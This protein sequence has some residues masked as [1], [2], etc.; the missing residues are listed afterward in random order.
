MQLKN[1][2]VSA[3]ALFAM[4]GGARAQADTV[5]YWRFEN[6]SAGAPVATV[7]DITGHGNTLAP[8]TTGNPT[9]P[10]YTQ[11]NPG[12]PLHPSSTNALALDYA[13]VNF[14]DINTAAATGDINSHTFNQFTVEASVK[15]SG[16]GGYQTF[17]CKEGHGIPNSD[18]ADLASLY[19]QSPGPGDVGGQNI[20][21]IR[22]SQA[23]GH[24]IVCNG[25]TQ[26]V[27]NVW[28]NVAAVSDGTSLRLYVQAPGGVYNLDRAVPFK[29]QMFNQNRNW[30]VGRGY[31]ANNAGDRFGGQL[32]EVRVSDTALTPDA[33]L[34]APNGAP[35]TAATLAGTAYDSGASLSWTTVAGA[36]SYTLQRGTKPGGPYSTLATGLLNQTYIDSGLSDGTT[37]YYV[38]TASNAAGTGPKSNELAL[39]PLA[40]ITGTGHF[41]INF[42]SNNGGPNTTPMGPAEVAGVDPVANWNNSAVLSPGN[43]GHSNTTGAPVPLVD[44]AGNAISATVDWQGSGNGWASGIADTP[45]DFR[46]M[47]GY[48]DTGDTS[49]HTITVNGLSPAKS[50]LV[51]VY[52][53]PAENNRTGSHTIGS[54]T[55]YISSAS[56]PFT[57]TYVRSTSTDPLKPGI[58]NYC[59][60]TVSGQNSFTLTSTPDTAINGTRAVV[61]GIQVLALAVPAPPANLAAVGLDKSVG[62]T[63]N[64]V[65][66]AVSY[67]VLRSTTKGG[68]YT[69]IATGVI[70]TGYTDTGLTNGTTYYY[71][72]QS[73]NT[74]GTSPNSNEAFATPIAAAV[75]AGD[76]LLGTYYTGAALDFSA[77]NGTPFLTHIDPTINF[78]VDDPGLP[79]SPTAFPAG[80]PHDLFTTVWTGKFQAPYTGSYVIGAVTDDGVRLTVNGQTATDAIL[81]G[82]TLTALPAQ[83]LTAG[84]KYDV[85]I[86]YFQNGGGSAAQFVYSYN[87]LPNAL[88]PQ[89]QLFSNLTGVPL[90]PANLTAVAGLKSVVLNW[91]G[92]ALATG[93]SVKRST[94]AGGPYTTIAT[95]LTV[96][97]YKDTAVTGG[98]TYYYVVSATNGSGESANSNE[99]F[100]TPIAAYKPVAYWRFE[101]GTA[102]THVD[103]TTPIADVSG[104]GNVLTTYLDDSAPTYRTNNPGNPTNPL[105]TNA[106]SL[107]FSE[108]P[109]PQV[110]FRELNTLNATGDINSHVFGQFTVE[111]SVYFNDLNGY[112]TFV[113]KNGFQFPGDTIGGDASFY[114]QKPDI[115]NTNGIPVVSVRSH[116]G[117]TGSFVIVQGS[118]PLVTGK[119]YNV[120]AVA[121]GYT[122]SLYLQST[123]GG[124]YNLENSLPFTG[125]M[126]IQNA[127]WS[128][129]RGFY[130]NASVDPF[131]GLADEVRISDIALD[132]SQF[133]FAAVSGATVTGTV[134]LEGVTDLS[135]V[136]PV[137]PL[138]KFHVIFRNTATSV[139][140]PYDVTLATAAGSPKGTFSV[141]GVPAGTYNVIVKGAKN[142]AVQVSGVVVSATSGTVPAVLLPAG[143]SNGD[144]SVDSSDF[145]TLIGAFN[146]DG[147]IPGS[148]YDPAVDFNFDG[149]VDSS[150]FGLLIGQFNN[151]GAI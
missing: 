31:Y 90:N 107:D 51:Y 117:S 32:D 18:T 49:T 121:D 71:V 97:N 137:A 143:D 139:E 120:A 141:S 62:L 47:K 22:A 93:Y 58:G 39:T 35:T 4:L 44:S 100:A 13:P 27:P 9:P 124:A 146:T 103:Y 116:Q 75:G 29:G 19:F 84:Q 14:G 118:T 140:T 55:Y 104:N 3:F 10:L 147:S 150:D 8:P 1:K 36:A 61:N 86:E 88:V 135:A 145:G 40:A 59:V 108:A 125:G 144:N 102:D 33:F 43:G 28:Y 6:G 45:G 129:G 115:G 15:F 133:L 23:D 99:A 37:Y 78:A 126:V 109:G 25:T 69:S 42:S 95:S 83:T 12:N 56:A 66:A 48:L 21:S 96:T 113:G 77:E 7:P 53:A 17:V 119:W 5:A 24:F 11:D 64:L 122:L 130:G 80:V 106:L 91:N 149:L 65:S 26:L 70:G 151:I 68:P 54:Q 41:S 131:R 89:T 85:K 123:P 136:S 20:V 38:V 148:G 110:P 111:A 132:P 72:V 46:M 134:S 114:F 82:P 105:L 60:F 30:A 57:G 34:F 94:T 112:Q 50:Y 63:W 101:G 127:P 142:L 79:F 138:G 76:G 67:N 16:F 2:V 92:A 73:V 128:V 81:R 52:D 74:I 87:G 98:T